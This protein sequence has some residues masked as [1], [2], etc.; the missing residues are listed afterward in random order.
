VIFF[1]SPDN[2]RW[3]GRKI[4]KKLI[5]SPIVST[6]VILELTQRNVFFFCGGGSVVNLV[7][8]PQKKKKSTFTFVRRIKL[9]DLSSSCFLH[10]K[11]QFFRSSDLDGAKQ[12]C[13]IFLGATWK[14]YT[15]WPQYVNTK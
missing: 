8:T 6:T 11:K 14:K 10:L 15:K 1:L 5:S 12:G 3:L 13:Q 4:E 2:G 9:S 7:I